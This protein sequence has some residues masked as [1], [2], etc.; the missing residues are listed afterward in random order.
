MSKRG[1]KLYLDDIEDA[2]KKIEEYTSGLVADQFYEDYKTI[3]AVIKNLTVI[4]E[5]S[6]NIPPE[7]K[8]KYSEVPWEEIAGM[9]NKVVHEYFG[10]DEEILWKTIEEDLPIFKEQILKIEIE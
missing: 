8:E 6:K 5:A 10:V 1:V 3:D 2:I 7:I 9:R 4:G